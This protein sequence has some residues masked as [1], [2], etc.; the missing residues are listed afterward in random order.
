M[1]Y[2]G[3][4][5][6]TLFYATDRGISLGQQHE[7]NGIDDHIPNFVLLR[8]QRPPMQ[9]KQEILGFFKLGL[10]EQFAPILLRLVK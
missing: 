6:P 2:V 8:W 9:R 4:P 3:E 1:R 5:S 7:F 10:S